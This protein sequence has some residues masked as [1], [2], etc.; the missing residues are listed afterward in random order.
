MSFAMISP[1]FSQTQFL[2]LLAHG[3]GLPSLT[4]LCVFP[5]LCQL[6][7]LA[8]ITVVLSCVGSKSVQWKFWDFMVVALP[9][10]AWA[11]AAMH[12][13]TSIAAFFIEGV[14]IGGVAG[15]APILRVIFGNRYNQKVLS[16]AFLLFV[17]LL[18]FGIGMT[19]P[20]EY[21][22]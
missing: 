4:T 20:I 14:C 7:P 3:V 12:Q 18:S 6:V 22:F 17:C 15:L 2:P 19:G 21:F 11:T 8:V 10:A 16:F 1:L 5:G 13:E 9:F